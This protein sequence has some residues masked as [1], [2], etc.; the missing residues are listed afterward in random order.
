MQEKIN[1]LNALLP[2][3]PFVQEQIGYGIKYAQEAV[4]DDVA[5]LEFALDLAIRLIKI[6]NKHSSKNFYS[7]RPA[8]CALLFLVRDEKN[9]DMFKTE[10]NS[11]LTTLEQFREFVG[12]FKT[13]VKQAAIFLAKAIMA[14]EKD[15]S[16]LIMNFLIEQVKTSD[17]LR[18][19]YISVDLRLNGFEMTG[20]LYDSYNKLLV[21]L[22][23]A[24]F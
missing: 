12:L 3:V 8:L 10:T 4:G 5:E 16:V 11:V 6:S 19:A 22:N 1:E 23:K 24:E 20:A 15:L 14:E 9:L 7:Y 17:I 21:D 18:V 13:N 2:T